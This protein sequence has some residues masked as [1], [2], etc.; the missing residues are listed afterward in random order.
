MQALTLSQALELLQQLVAESDHN[1]RVASIL[2]KST[3]SRAI[4]KGSTISNPKRLLVVLTTVLESE[5]TRDS[6][7]MRRGLDK[8]LTN[9]SRQEWGHG[10]GFSVKGAP[11]AHL[12]MTG[13]GRLKSIDGQR[14]HGSET[15]HSARYAGGKRRQTESSLAKLGAHGAPCVALRRGQVFRLRPPRRLRRTLRRLLPKVVDGTATQAMRMEVLQ[16]IV[17]LQRYV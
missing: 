7:A 10:Q 17:Q 15:L 13:S 11:R 3:I 12:G 1:R 2:A 6:N 8:D 5:L 14:W 4:D 16:A 9:A